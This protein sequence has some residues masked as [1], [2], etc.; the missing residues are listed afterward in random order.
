MRKPTLAAL[1]NCSFISDVRTSLKLKHWNSFAVLTK[2]ANEA[3]TVAVF[4]FQFY[5]TECDG[6]K[7]ITKYLL[8][9]TAALTGSVTAVTS[10]DNTPC[11]KKTCD[12]IFYHNF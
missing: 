12:Y 3:E 2:Y 1:F 4:L 7:T 5:F 6:L 11:P 8:R 9:T 10:S